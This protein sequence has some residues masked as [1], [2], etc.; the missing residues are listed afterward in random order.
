LKDLSE[1]CVGRIDLR[2]KGVSVFILGPVVIVAAGGNQF[3]GYDCF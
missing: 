3:D 1:C 2:R